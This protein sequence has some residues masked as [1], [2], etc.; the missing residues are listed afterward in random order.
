MKFIKDHNRELK[1]YIEATD[2]SRF[3]RSNEDWTEDESE[4]DTDDMDEEEEVAEDEVKSIRQF[5]VIGQIVPYYV[6]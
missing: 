6:P 2:E 4:A 5:T 3:V 1:N